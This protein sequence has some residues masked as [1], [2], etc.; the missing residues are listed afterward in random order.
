MDILILTVF[1]M[2]VL[3]IKDFEPLVKLEAVVKFMAIVNPLAF[4]SRELIVSLI[5]LETR[6][7]HRTC[8]HCDAYGPLWNAIPL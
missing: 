6:S 1:I 3:P 4:M 8:S 2:A 5:A 7:C